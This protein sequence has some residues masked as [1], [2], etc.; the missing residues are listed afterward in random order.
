MKDPLFQHLLDALPSDDNWD[1]NIPR[2][3]GLKKAGEKRYWYQGA[4]ETT[5][6]SALDD[7][8]NQTF[9]KDL[10]KKS[11]ALGD[12]DPMK[13]LETLIQGGHSVPPKVFSENNV[14]VASLK[15][16]YN[17]TIP[18]KVVCMYV[19]AFRIPFHALIVSKVMLR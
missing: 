6:G 1:E 16:T 4:S 10:N 13:D 7:K 17:D 11:K 12:G 9:F 15:Q 2:E 19:S 14:V 3:L 5:H 18:K 8:R